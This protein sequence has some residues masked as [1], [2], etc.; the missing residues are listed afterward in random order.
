MRVVT[1]EILRTLSKKSQIEEIHVKRD[2]LITPSAKEYI[3]QHDIEIIYDDEENINVDESTEKE[4]DIKE[5]PKKE[6]KKATKH[7]SYY[8]GK[9][10]ESKPEYMTHLYG[11]KLVYKNDP[12]IR[13][14]GKLDSFQ[15]SLVLV[16]KEADLAEKKSLVEDI[17]KLLELSRT[18]LR[19]EVL[20]EPLEELNLF[21]YSD[22]EL[23]EASHN[24][25]RY[26]GVEHITPDYKMDIL[27]LKLNK[28]RS[29]VRELEIY[30]LDAFQNRDGY[31][32]EDILQALNRFS[33]IIYVV[34]YRHLTSKY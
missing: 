34:M 15:S 24:P 21:G 6:L 13:F 23:R 17:E 7:I 33:S 1:E 9:E 18:I 5:L 31:D 26:F 30:A 16:Q 22:G 10:Y 29:D 2:S 19:S 8:S 12:R 28:L 4:L 27:T 32:R 14:R 11:N 20:D 3:N 25:K